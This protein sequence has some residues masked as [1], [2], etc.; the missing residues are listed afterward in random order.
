MAKYFAVCCFLTKSAPLHIQRKN[1]PPTVSVGG[2]CF[3]KFESSVF[4]ASGASSNIDSGANA[5]R[6]N[7]SRNNAGANAFKGIASA[8][9][10]QRDKQF[11]SAVHRKIIAS[12]SKSQDDCI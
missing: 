9:R 11:H 2:E 12:K 4:P 5:A 7:K 6:Q 1:P 10:K 8:A 3:L